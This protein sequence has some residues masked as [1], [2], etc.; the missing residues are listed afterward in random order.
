MQGFFIA[1]Q[2][3]GRMTVTRSYSTLLSKANM[4]TPDHA[5]QWQTIGVTA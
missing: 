4:Q 2:K 1:C 5:N 3:Q